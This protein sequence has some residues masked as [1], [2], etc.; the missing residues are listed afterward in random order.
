MINTIASI[1]DTIALADL[2]FYLIGRK[3]RAKVSRKAKASEKY[4]YIL[5]K[6][7]ID[8]D[9]KKHLFETTKD[10]FQSLIQ[11]NY[12]LED[13]N[14][15]SDDLSHRLLT[16]NKSLAFINAINTQLGTNTV[17]TLKNLNQ[18]STEGI[19]LWAYMIKVGYINEDT[20][21]IEYIYTFRKMSKGQIAY[22]DTK[23]AIFGYWDTN[24]AE[25][26]PLK[27]ETIEIGKNLDCVYHASTF[28]ILKKHSF[29]VM[30]SLEDDYIEKASSTIVEMQ[31]LKGITG[32][33]LIHEFVLKDA[34]LRKKI[35]QMAKHNKFKDFDKNKVG[36]ALKWAEKHNENLSLDKDGNIV[37]DSPE[38]ALAIIRMF[39]DYYK[40]GNWSGE[41]YATYSGKM[42]QKKEES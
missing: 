17:S 23:K 3:K 34:M 30:T 15:I 8:A 26:K 25:F 2:S 6:T 7:D 33:H 18:L 16:Y 5:Y 41:T 19:E 12:E 37:I 36:D 9:L 39:V 11:K 4:D 1:L 14:P 20:S 28:Y 35:I 32:V 42:L 27:I 10:Q 38:S 22:E 21:K 40:T 29:E 24:N 13:Y 31:N